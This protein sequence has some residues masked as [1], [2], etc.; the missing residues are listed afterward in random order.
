MS[1][2]I[3]GTTSGH[4][5]VE[6]VTFRLADQWLGIP[7]LRGA[8]YKVSTASDGRDALTYLERGDRYDIIISD[9]DMPAVDG[10]AL[11]REI[12]ANPAWSDVPLLALTGRSTPADRE[13]ARACGFDEFLVKFDREAVLSALQRLAAAAGVPA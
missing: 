2:A 6:Y 12:R 5:S 3:G 8:G 10:F 9:I 11:A 13:R 1:A 4:G 7:V